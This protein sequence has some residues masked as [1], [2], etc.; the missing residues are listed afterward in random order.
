MVSVGFGTGFVIIEAGGGISMSEST[1]ALSSNCRCLVP[2][3][4]GSV[5]GEPVSTIL[6]LSWFSRCGLS[7][8]VLD[9]GGV[10]S[11]TEV[12][13]G[14]VGQTNVSLRWRRTMSQ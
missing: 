4:L 3:P 6:D 14:E 10:K 1:P 11:G 9:S 13:T 8:S 7:E 12:V 5:D 2:Y